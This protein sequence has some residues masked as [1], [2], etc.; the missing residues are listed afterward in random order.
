MNGT[1]EVFHIEDW[2][3][4]PHIEETVSVV[5]DEDHYF[6]KN[7][8]AG[9]RLELWYVVGGGGGHSLE[10]EDFVTES[11]NKCV[12]TII[13]ELNTF[14]TYIDGP[15]G[16]MKARVQTMCTMIRQCTAQQFTYLLPTCPPSTTHHAACRLNTAT[17]N[18][19]DSNRFLVT[20]LREF[21]VSLQYLRARGVTCLPL[22]TV[23]N[24]WTNQPLLRMQ[25]QIT[26]QLQ[27]LRKVEALRTLPTEP[28]YTEG[29]LNPLN[30]HDVA[31]RR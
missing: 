10:V 30:I 28:L 21:D 18:T 31:R 11:V 7:L 9:C 4:A 12:D 27:A 6:V 2:S 17:T 26:M 16:T 15:N 23:F 29:A 20:S 22:I 25:K 14:T 5:Y 3:V 13:D 1:D 24:I 19:S 8:V